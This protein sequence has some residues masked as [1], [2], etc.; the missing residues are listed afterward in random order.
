MCGIERR[1]IPLQPFVV[2]KTARRDNVVD[3][4]QGAALAS[5]SASDNL[6]GPASAVDYELYLL[7]LIGSEVA[8]PFATAARPVVVG[9]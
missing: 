4:A 9:S 3:V 1:E 5:C 8:Q 2:A 7:D 6:E